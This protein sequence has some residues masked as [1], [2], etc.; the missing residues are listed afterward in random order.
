[1]ATKPLTDEEIVAQIAEARGR[2]QHAQAT[3]PHAAT[4]HFDPATRLLVVGLTNGAGFV[5]PI[6]HLPELA[7]ATDAQIAAVEVGPA[8][9]GLSWDDLDV[10]LTVAGLARLVF[11]DR[12]L[13]QAAAAQ[14]GSVRS[15][16]KAEAARANGAKGGRPRKPSTTNPE[17]AM[18]W[19]LEEAARLAARAAAGPRRRRFWFRRRAADVEIVPAKEANDRSVVAAER[20]I[21][22]ALAKGTK[23][24]VVKG[25]VIKG[26]TKR[27]VMKN[28]AEAKNRSVADQPAKGPKNS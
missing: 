21:E 12:A 17:D 27:V 19:Q 4:A 13:A 24:V 8:G 3:E 22:Q 6:A 18:R 26:G 25:G 1:M 23:V 20:V 7:D 2:A 9:V 16:A 10:D 14:A 11:G 15:A 28:T 5:V